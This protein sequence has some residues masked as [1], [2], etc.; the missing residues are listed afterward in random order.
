MAKFNRVELRGAA[1]ILD[2]TY[3]ARTVPQLEETWAQNIADLQTEL[4]QCQRQIEAITGRLTRLEKQR[5]VLDTFADGM[6]KRTEEEVFAA[7]MPQPPPS[8]LPQYDKKH[9]KHGKK[10]PLQREESFA[11]S[12]NKRSIA[13]VRVT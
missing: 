11:S 3:T 4:R 2:V 7:V 9:D 13:E 12:L 1:T 6:T 8:Q 5:S 10:T